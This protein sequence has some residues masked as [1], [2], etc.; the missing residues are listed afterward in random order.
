MSFNNVPDRWLNYTAVGTRIENTPFVALKC[1]LGDH[2]L[3]HLN[4]KEQFGL[5]EMRM[6]LP[7]VSLVID[8]SNT[9]RYYDPDEFR[10]SDIQH[11][12]IRL[13][14]R[15]L[16]SIDLLKQFFLIVDN[17]I[18][19]SNS[20]KKLI[21]V[22]CTHGVNRTG[23]FICS[24]MICKMNFTYKSAVAE[25][26]KARGHPIERDIYLRQLK[27]YEIWPMDFICG[28]DNSFPPG[29]NRKKSRKCAIKYAESQNSQQLTDVRSSYFSLIN[30]D[31]FSN[32]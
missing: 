23:F 11:I 14:G 2:F 24:Y 1:P 29:D 8:L 25:F 32:H 20:N 22:H 5:N 13:P 7:E 16:P 17:F 27:I 10:A 30:R 31:Y 15:V 28:S 9:N 3:R 4:V 12:K 18:T 21:G 6:L 26:S 19:E